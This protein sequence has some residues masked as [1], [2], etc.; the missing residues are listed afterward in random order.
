MKRIGYDADSERY[1]F[2]DRDGSIWVGE[3]GVEVGE[4]TR[5]SSLFFER[6][7]ALMVNANGLQYQPYPLPLFG[8]P[9]TT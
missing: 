6:Q 1:Y 2:R 5:G 9:R 8:G 4:M 3:E 7:H